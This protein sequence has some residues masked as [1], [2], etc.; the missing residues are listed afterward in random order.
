VDSYN[1]QDQIGRDG[2]NDARGQGDEAV[3]DEQDA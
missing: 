2:E 1:T 3:D